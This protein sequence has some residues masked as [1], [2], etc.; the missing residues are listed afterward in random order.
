MINSNSAILLQYNN[1][2]MLLTYCQKE[3]VR[4]CELGV[5]R[6]VARKIEE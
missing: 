3:S 1:K 6:T 4:Q 2:S 5:I